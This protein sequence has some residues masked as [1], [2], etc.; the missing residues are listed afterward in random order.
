MT[1]DKL[2]GS[3]T[4]QRKIITHTLAEV[5]CIVDYVALKDCMMLQIY[6]IFVS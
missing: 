1:S 6:E 4:Q 3:G 2:P 5:I